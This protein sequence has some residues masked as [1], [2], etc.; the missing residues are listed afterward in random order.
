MLQ[1]AYRSAV[2]R[3]D[4]AT[5]TDESCLAEAAGFPVYLVPDQSTNIKI[6]VNDDLVFAESLARS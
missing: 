6:T 5:A 1:A 4:L 3:N 2:E